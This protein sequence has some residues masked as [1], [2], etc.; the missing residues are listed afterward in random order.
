M[1]KDLIDELLDLDMGPAL[2]CL[3]EGSSSCVHKGTNHRKHVNWEIGQVFFFFLTLRDTV[4]GRGTNVH[5]T[6]TRKKTVK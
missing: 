6:M 2:L 3:L 5:M 1:V 4:F